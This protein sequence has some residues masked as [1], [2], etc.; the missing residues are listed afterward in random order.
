MMKPTRARLNRSG[1]SQRRVFVAMA[2]LALLGVIA[3]G[4]KGATSSA[5]SDADGDGGAAGGDDA[6]GAGGALA[7]DGGFDA[8]VDAADDRA[9]A[10]EV[11]DGGTVV[12]AFAHPGLLHTRADIDRMRSMVAA[13][14]QPYLNGF[15]LLRVHAQSQSDYVVR[16]GFS[17]MGRNPD[18][19]KTET[20]TDANA[21]YQN[22]IMWVIT[23]DAAFA[24]KSMQILDTWSTSLTTISGADA[25]LAAGIYGFKFVNAAEILR[26]TG[27]GW[28]V[29]NIARAESLF[30]NVFYPVIQDFATFANGNW[31]L[32][33]VM[34]MMSIGVFTNDRPMFDRAVAWLMSGTD[35]GT[36][37]HYIVNAAGQCQESGRDQ[38]HAQLGLGYAAQAAEI[39]WNQEIDVYS[40]FANRLLAGFE[41]TAHYNL[42]SDVPFV[43]FTDTTGKYHQTIISADQRGMFR[44]IYEMVFNHFQNRRGIACP[45]TAQVATMLRPEGAAFQADHPGFGTLLFTR[46]P[47][48]P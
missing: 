45:F 4:C 34:T 39:A 21:A 29:A 40:A 26:Y 44:P 15:N 16:G 43:E 24:N 7:P 18:V 8:G 1:V 38:S 14:Q 11:G 37:T 9:T 20:E 35:N 28:P 47:A 3:P 36:I 17:E 27:T 48:V 5:A 30:R 10:G 19:R 42:G 23:G 13:G 46:P 6:R 25:I 32:S 31:T 33:C 41:Y 12:A 22:A 2:G